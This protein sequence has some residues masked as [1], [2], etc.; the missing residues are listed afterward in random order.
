METSA[1]AETYPEYHGDQQQQQQQQ[2]SSSS[3]S[4]SKN[5]LYIFNVLQ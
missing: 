1:A 4:S 5:I 2:Q 3:N